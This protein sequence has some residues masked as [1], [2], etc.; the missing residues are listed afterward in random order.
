MARFVEYEDV[1]ALW[2]KYHYMIAA[3]A[4]EFDRELRNL[5]TV[6]ARC[7]GDC[8]HFRKDDNRIGHGTCDWYKK[9]KLSID[10]CSMWGVKDNG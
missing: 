5:Q 2:D 7:C 1:L 9:E 10:C 8:R 6:D 4:T 3:R